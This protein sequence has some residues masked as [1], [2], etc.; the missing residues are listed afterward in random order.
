MEQVRIY[1]ATLYGGRQS[2]GAGLN[3]EER[4]EIARL[5]EQMKVDAI[6]AGF[7]IASPRQFESVRA[8]AGKCTEH[9]VAYAQALAAEGADMLITAGESP[10]L[11]MS[12]PSAARACA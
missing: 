11:S 2:P 3:T 12:A 5:L 1:D 9:V 7:P 8:L 6:Q 4:L 10:V